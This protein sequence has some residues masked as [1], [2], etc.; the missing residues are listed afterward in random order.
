MD[1]AVE[2]GIYVS[3]KAKDKLVQLMH[4]AQVDESHFVRVSVVGGGCSGL[5][6]KLDFDNE[7]KPM[8]QQFEDKGIKL[9]CDLKS[10]LYLVNTELDFSDGLN[11]KGF[12]F[13]NPN[14]SRSCGCGESFAV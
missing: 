12:N 3:D 7:L 14:A 11:G 1:V 13:I 10:F 8:D 5:S 2:N 6:Y 9:V 4:D